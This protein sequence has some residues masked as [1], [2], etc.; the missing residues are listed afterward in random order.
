MKVLTVTTGKGNTITFHETIRRATGRN[1]LR[2][3]ILAFWNAYQ[4]Q[5]IVTEKG[6]EIQFDKFSRVLTGN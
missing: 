4:A 1:A 6:V 3:F 5:V 2:K